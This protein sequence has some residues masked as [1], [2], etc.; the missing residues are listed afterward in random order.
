[1]ISST[2]QNIIDTTGVAAKKTTGN[3]DLGKDDF[4]NLLMTELKYQDFNNVKDDKEFIAQLA[5]FSSV[6][7]TKTMSDNLAASLQFQKLGQATNL[8][9][10]DVE[11]KAAKSEDP[12][13]KGKVDEVKMVS[14]V[15]KLVV[16]G[17]NYDLSDVVSL[18]YK[19]VASA[20]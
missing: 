8:L 6:E 4:L 13:I 20:I 18:N 7:Q 17:T 1:M 19:S 15:P 14:G 3:S 10:L 12:N 11:I 16:G 5:Q 9:G 2:I